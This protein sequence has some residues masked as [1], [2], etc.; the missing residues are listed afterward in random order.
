MLV[1]ALVAAALTGAA[2]AKPIGTI[3]VV[4]KQEVVQKLDS[5]SELVKLYTEPA[6]S[7][8]P[9]FLLNILGDSSYNQG[10]DAGMLF[11]AQ[12]LEN[13]QN[14][15]DAL[16]KALPKGL[17]Q[18]ALQKV[19]EEFMDWQWDSYLSQELPEEYLDE[20]KGLTEGGIAAGVDGDVGV[21][22]SRG[23]T[24]ANLPGDVQDI[25]FVLIDEYKASKR[26][27]ATPAQLALIDKLK[28]VFAHYRGHHCSMFSVWGS[29]TT[30]GSLFSARNLDWLTDLGINKYK[31]VTVHHPPNG[32]AHATVAYGGI[33]GALSGVSAAGLSVHEA[34][35]ES[36][37]DTYRGFPWLLR[38]REVMT[39]TDTLAG[40]RSMWEATNNTVGFNHM[41]AS[42]SEKGAIAMETMAGYTAF[43]EPMDA[44]EVDAVDPYTGDVYG[45]PLP[46]ALYRTNHGYDPVTQENYQWYGDGQYDNSKRR[47]KQIYDSFVEYETNGEK[48]GA[49]EAVVVTSAI[50]IKGDG[51]DEYNC[52]PDLYT[53]GDNILSVTFEP[54]A[55]TLYAAF[56]DKAGEDWIPAAC[57]PYVK[58]DLS[59]WF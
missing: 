28:E 5:G 47:Y 21:A 13:Y 36:K 31:L 33:W 40:A 19:V 42:A 30:E 17:L 45:Y 52:N 38:L 1:F 27:S 41:V 7:S 15:F 53:Q 37:K 58:I 23:I 44:R 10:F 35:L 9:I 12:H 24:L 4:S 55:Q 50:G 54:G 43:F 2:V 16:F 34:N 11:G 56:E 26:D 49:K 3:G 32:I 48:I 25:I 57:N 20:L 6:Y 51:T 18:P 14:L 22:L 8:N 46:E 29:R 59:Q 39:K